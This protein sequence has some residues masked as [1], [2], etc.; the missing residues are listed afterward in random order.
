M[1]RALGIAGSGSES[2]TILPLAA[3][4]ELDYEG[5]TEEETMPLPETVY[6]HRSILITG[7]SSGIGAELAVQLAAHGARLGLCARRASELEQVAERVK[8]AGGRALPLSC[9]V[10]DPAA[11]K[12]AH[13]ELVAAHGPVEVAFLNAGIGDTTSVKNFEAARVK[14]LFEVNVFGV[15]Y[16]LEAIFPAM[17]EAGSGVV[18]VTSSLAAARGT[19]GTGAYAASKAALSSLLE[20]L[21]ADARR[22]GIQISILEPGFIRTP[23]TDKN[24]FKMPFLIDVSEAASLTLERVAEGQA[25]IRFPWQMAAVMQVI[26]HLPAPVYDGLGKRLLGKRD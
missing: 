19:P 14:R 13:A 20:S 2:T 15:A 26:R 16:W 12:Q 4:L 11:V 25:W 22:Y 23:M 3:W 7:A 1:A 10:A 24:K 8:A 18:A 17:R 5:K 6:K 9:D 21:Q